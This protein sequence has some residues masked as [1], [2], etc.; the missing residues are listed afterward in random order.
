MGKGKRF[1]RGDKKY[2]NELPVETYKGKFPHNDAIALQHNPLP[3][4]EHGGVYT[5]M[6]ADI[7]YEELRAPSNHRLT[8][9]DD[10]GDRSTKV[11]SAIGWYVGMIALVVSV[12]ALFVWPFWTGLSG[13]I[14]SV[15]AYRQ[16]TRSI[17]WVSG[18]L[19]VVAIMMSIIQYFSYL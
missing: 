8:T 15:L 5:E 18:T 4:T 7:T 12:I 2:R 10:D 6:G 14:L 9:Y 19:S 17:A 3:H 1:S 16:G 11:N 13:L